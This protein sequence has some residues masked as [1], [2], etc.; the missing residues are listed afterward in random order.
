MKVKDG[1]KERT[2]LDIEPNQAAIVL[3]IFN[4]ANLGKG[5]MEIAKLLNREGIAGPKSEGWKKTTI[6]KILTQ[7]IYTGTLVWGRNSIR[8]LPP[9]RVENAYPAIVDR[10]TFDHIQSLM[11]ERAPLSLHPKRVASRYLLSGLAR[12]GYCGKALVGQEAKSGKFTYYICG[13]LLKKGA[14]ACPTR[15]LNSQKFE[16]LIITKIKEHILTTENL[17]RLVNIVN[18]EMD[19]LSGEYHAESG[20][21][22]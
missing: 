8:G 2:R 3:R 4:E 21:S 11:K 19:S 6:G 16:N 12:C 20:K 9:I 18:E 7:E 15:Y 5:Q 13:T 22:Y 10:E 1:E 17:T 14:E